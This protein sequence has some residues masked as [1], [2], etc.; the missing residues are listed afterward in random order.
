MLGAK[1][2]A[3]AIADTVN[4][5]VAGSRNSFSVAV[6]AGANIGVVARSGTGGGGDGFCVAVLVGSG[7]EGDSPRFCSDSK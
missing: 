4:I 5:V 1:V 3:A 6:T 2:F 7:G